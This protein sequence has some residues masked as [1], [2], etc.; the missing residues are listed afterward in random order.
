MR[1]YKQ[2]QLTWKVIWPKIGCRIRGITGTEMASRNLR[3]LRMA[4]KSKDLIESI[5]EEIIMETLNIATGY[6]QKNK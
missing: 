4:Q 1:C 6:S 5:S 2:S 3:K